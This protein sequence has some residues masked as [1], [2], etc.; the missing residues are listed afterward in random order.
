MYAA[1]KPEKI[2]P[3]KGKF[4][5]TTEPKWLGLGS[6]PVERF[7]GN[8]STVYRSSEFSD[9]VWKAFKKGRISE[10][11]MYEIK[12]D[13]SSVHDYGYSSLFIVTVNNDIFTIFRS[14]ISP[15]IR[16]SNFHVSRHYVSR[17][18]LF[19]VKSS[20]PQPL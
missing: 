13:R 11:D 14:K 2:V 12:K 20:A 18:I 7:I 6:T 17:K 8:N 5:Q 3:S 4:E 1:K 15:K 9:S 19:S 10:N 16:F